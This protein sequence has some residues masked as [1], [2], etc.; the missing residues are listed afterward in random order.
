VVAL[1]VIQVMFFEVEPQT[2]TFAD[3]SLL[4]HLKDVVLALSAAF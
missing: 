1:T 2:I 4:E 3:L